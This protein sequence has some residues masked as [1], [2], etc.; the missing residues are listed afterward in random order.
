MKTL[1]STGE[2]IRHYKLNASGG[3]AEWSKVPCTDDYRMHVPA[4]DF[5]VSG[6]DEIKE[7]IFGWLT[8]IGAKQEL[9]DIVEFEASV[10]CYLHISDKDG[11]VLDIVE[12]FQIDDEGRVKEIW[13]L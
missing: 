5:D 10:T 1:S 9:V 4:M 2:A 3:Y 6:A 7:V 12:V 8:E 13:A 11:N